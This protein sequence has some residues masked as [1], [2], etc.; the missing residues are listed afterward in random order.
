MTAP[1]TEMG[2]RSWLHDRL[3]AHLTA[4][5]APVPVWDRPPTTQP[6]VST[7]EYVVVMPWP[8]QTSREYLTTT[9]TDLLWPVTILTAGMTKRGVLHTLDN[10]AEAIDGWNPHPTDPTFP[11]FGHHAGGGEVLPEGTAGFRPYST[12]IVYAIHAPNRRYTT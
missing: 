8:G 11:A 10:V 3:M 2:P 4:A 6:P 1:V 9:A 5:L 7:P 12:S